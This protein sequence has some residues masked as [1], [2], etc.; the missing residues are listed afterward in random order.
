MKSNLKPMLF[1]SIDVY[2]DGEKKCQIQDADVPCEG[3]ELFIP[4]IGPQDTYIVEEVKRRYRHIKQDHR[5]YF[6][7]ETHQVYVKPIEKDK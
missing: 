2:V 6:V 1:R 5:E 7:P 3:Q 4:G